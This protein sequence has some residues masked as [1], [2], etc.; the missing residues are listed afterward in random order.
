MNAEH[1]RFLARLKELQGA[2]TDA[3]FARYVGV[4]A[5][6]LKQYDKGSFPSIA[7]AAKIAE[8][9]GVSID[10]LSGKSDAPKQGAAL[11]MRYLAEAISIVEEWLE[12]EARAMLPKK[13][14]DVVTQIYQFIMDDATEGQQPID[15]KQVQRILRLVA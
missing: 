1:E 14:A 15:R 12:T 3:A 6:T 5:T 2:K 7:I 13:K 9:H 8:A 4:P 10:W 11:N